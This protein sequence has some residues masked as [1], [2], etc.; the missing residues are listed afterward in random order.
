MEK[1]KT[2]SFVFQSKKGGMYSYFISKRNLNDSPTH[3]IRS[4]HAIAKAEKSNHC[5]VSAAFDTK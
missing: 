4:F 3:H 2:E 1:L 5:L